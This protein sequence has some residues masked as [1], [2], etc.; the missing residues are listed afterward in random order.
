MSSKEDF[1]DEKRIT[2]IFYLPNNDS[3]TVGGWSVLQ[4][5]FEMQLRIPENFKY[6]FVEFSGDTQEEKYKNVRK[7]YNITK[8][9]RG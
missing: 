6:S 8:R 7:F 9:Y 5:F 3:I 1:I 2:A 4:I